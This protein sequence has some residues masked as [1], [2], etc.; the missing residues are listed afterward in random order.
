MNLILF[1]TQA[2]CTP[3]VHFHCYLLLVV[4]CISESTRAFSSKAPFAD[5]HQPRRS[6]HPTTLV[7]LPL[8]S[9]HVEHS[10]SHKYLLRF[11]CVAIPDFANAS[12]MLLTPRW[13]CSSVNAR[14]CRSCNAVVQLPVQRGFVLQSLPSTWDF[15]RVLGAGVQYIHV[16]Y[17]TCSARYE[18]EGWLGHIIISTGEHLPPCVARERVQST[19]RAH[20]CALYSQTPPH[21]AILRSTHDCCTL[22]HDNSVRY[23]CQVNVVVVQC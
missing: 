14:G 4:V 16:L 20:K 11:S 12:L 21:C 9:T 5:L 23:I 13:T 6:I 22:H 10:T 2:L 19:P 17:R 18:L 1:H 15:T 7:N 8:S 3:T